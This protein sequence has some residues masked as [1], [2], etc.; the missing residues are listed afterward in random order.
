MIAKCITRWTEGAFDGPD[1]VK[2]DAK[3]RVTQE[4]MAARNMALASA[5]H[6]Q[7]SCSEPDLSLLESSSTPAVTLLGPP[8]QY[9]GDSSED[10]YAYMVYEAV[11]LIQRA[12]FKINIAALQMTAQATK[13][14]LK[15][16][17]RLVPGLLG[18]L[19]NDM[20]SDIE[21]AI[22]ESNGEPVAQLGFRTYKQPWLSVH[23]HS[24]GNSES[25]EMIQR[26]LSRKFF[27][28]EIPHT[29][30]SFSIPVE[31]TSS[32]GEDKYSSST[33]NRKLEVQ[34]TTGNLSPMKAT[35]NMQTQLWTKFVFVENGQ[36]V[37]FAFW[38]FTNDRQDSVGPA[39]EVFETLQGGPMAS[40]LGLVLSCMEDKMIEMVA[41]LVAFRLRL[42]KVDDPGVSQWLSRRGYT[43]SLGDGSGCCK[44][45]VVF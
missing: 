41:P 14:K 22:F 4:E 7:V 20:S 32:P 23:C 8:K 27:L 43:K 1:K 3:R 45:F 34:V 29:T 31:Q 36:T 2:A 19:L 40:S 5:G 28:I 10:R 39:M 35:E 38:S 16:Q 12:G 21:I 37:A 30:K 44:A 42:C 6:F 24:S 17:H 11:D 15:K 33:E 13:K 9:H 26:I 25:K 18:F